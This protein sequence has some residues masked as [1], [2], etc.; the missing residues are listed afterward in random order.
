MAIT[1]YTRRSPF[2]SPW[3][4]VEDM[5]HRLNRL[6]NQPGSVAASGRSPWS[7]PVNVEESKEEI[8]LTAELPGL[9]IED[10][11][12]EVE[13]NVLSLS[14]EKKEEVREEDERRHHVWERSFGSFRRQFTLPRTVK[15][16]KI[17]AHFKDGIL[18]VQ[19]PKAP[20]AKA[21]KIAIK[22]EG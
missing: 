20:E 7:P 1:R 21:R 5:T 13:N 11:E 15:S 14:G 9:N 10:V 22:A 16:A 2:L 6:F 4:E 12:I 17:T 8:L 3:L 18:H 19:M